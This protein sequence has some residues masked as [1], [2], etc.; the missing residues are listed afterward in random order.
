MSQA[1]RSASA[2]LPAPGIPVI[3]AVVHPESSSSTRP[4][5]ATSLRRPVKC[6]VAGGSPTKAAAVRFGRAAA[7]PASSPSASSTWSHA[8]ANSGVGGTLPLSTLLTCDLL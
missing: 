3:T 6:L 2:V 1:T 5:R 7:S 4:S 8:S